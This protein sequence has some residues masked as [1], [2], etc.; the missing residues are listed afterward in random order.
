MISL[1]IPPKKAISDVIKLLNEEAGKADNIKDNLN[2]KSVQNAMTYARER[3][4]L[5][6]KTPPNGLVLYAGTISSDNGKTDKKM[7]LDFEPFRPLGRFRYICDNSFHVED[8]KDLLEKDDIYGFIVMDGEGALFGTLQGNHRQ[9]LYKFDVD[10]PKK[11]GRGGQSAKR[12]ARLRL[13]KRHNY[14]RKVCEVATQVFIANDRPNINGLILAGSADFK[15]NLYKSEMFDLRLK[16]KVL[17]VL[18]ISYGGE[19]GFSQAVELSKGH[20][21]NVKFVQ[22]KEV[23]SGFFKEISVDSGL[24]VCGVS[25]TIRALEAGNIETLLLYE[26]LDMWRV[27]LRNK[28]D[29]SANIVFLTSD[30]LADPKYHVDANTK[31]ELEVVES[32]QLSEWI[33]ENYL[34]FGAKLRF[35]TGQSPEGFQ[36]VKGLGGIGGVS[37]YAVDVYE[38]D[39]DF[40]EEDADDDFL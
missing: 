5:Y 24:A 23:L 37:R 39:A 35:I 29:D 31:A 40:Y 13:E 15:N 25:D 21:T 3:L 19:N 32:M 10:L 36:F 2:R 20:L 33:A 16:P 17:E 22:E 11:H 28:G 1:M 38:R 14:L 30:Q 12:F 8:L 34:N 27:V 26:N 6:N 9:V 7:V 18:D 4:K